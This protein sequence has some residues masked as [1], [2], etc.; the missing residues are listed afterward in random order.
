MKLG[1]LES[2]ATLNALTLIVAGTVG[3]ATGIAV[4]G[5][6]LLAT[7][8]VAI[9]VGLCAGGVLYWLIRALKRRRS[10]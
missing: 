1:L 5:L 8:A 7:L 3:T 10:S 4:E 2:D 9:L 6:P